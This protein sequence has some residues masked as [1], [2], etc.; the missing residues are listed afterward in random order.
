MAPAPVL[1]ILGG[2][3]LG[4]MLALAAAKLGIKTRVLSDDRDAPAADVAEFQYAHYDDEAALSAF[5]NAVDVVTYEFENVPARTAQVLAAVKPVRPSAQVLAVTQDRWTE[6]SFLR[7]QGIATAPF[8]NIERDVDLAMAVGQIGTPAIV[9]TRRMGYD[10]KGQRLVHSRAELSGAWADLNKAHAILEGVVHFSREISVVAARGLNGTVA[11]YDP[12][13]NRHESHILKTTIAPALI[14]P[15]G[16]AQALEIAN[17]ILTALDYV[18]VMGVEMFETPAGILVNELAPRV[19]NSGHWTMDACTCSQ[20]EQ[21]VRAVM[22]WP[23]GPVDR[24]ADAEMTN[25]LGAE[26]LGWETRAPLPGQSLHL[27]GKADARPGR[28]MGHVT[29]LHPKT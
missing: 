15:E 19:H 3:Q 11:A 13:E 28:K 5:A 12:V 22:G 6:K 17:R 7:A 4:R 9:K 16:R 29:Q 27:Y 25:L 23:L 2:G 8:A 10:G 20:F 21:H 1:G 18:G 26:A 24:F 14:S